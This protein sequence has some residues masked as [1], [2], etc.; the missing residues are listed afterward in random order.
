MKVFTHFQMDQTVLNGANLFFANQFNI[1]QDNSRNRWLLGVVNAAP[2]V[3][4]RNQS[5]AGPFI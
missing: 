2:Y 4:V 1:P 5:P 3:S